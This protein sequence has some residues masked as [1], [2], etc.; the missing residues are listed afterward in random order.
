VSRFLI[1]HARRI[2]NATVEDMP[3]INW[4][5]RFW[6]RRTGACAP[7]APRRAPSRSSWDARFCCTCEATSGFRRS[8]I[9]QP[10]A[11]PRAGEGARPSKHA[12]HG[13]DVVPAPSLYFELT[14]FFSYP[15][16]MQFVELTHSLVCN[17]LGPRYLDFVGQIETL[18]DREF[19]WQSYTDTLVAAC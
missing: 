12:D 18:T 9:G 10:I 3:Q 1:P 19:I 11:V 8:A 16:V 6:P 17:S 5:L 14:S 7:G 4:V 15:K 13:V 2:A